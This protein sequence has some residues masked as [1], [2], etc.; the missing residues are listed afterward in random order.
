MSRFRLRM[1]LC[2]E[3]H[4]HLGLITPRWGTVQLPGNMDNSCACLWV[5]ASESRVWVIP[6][7]AGMMKCWQVWIHA[8]MCTMWEHVCLSVCGGASVMDQAIP[9]MTFLWAS[10]PVYV[11]ENEL[12]V[13]VCAW[14]INL[15]PQRQD[16]RAELKTLKMGECSGA[17]TRFQMCFGLLKIG[18]LRFKHFRG[19]FLLSGRLDCQR[20][21][22]L[23]VILES[24]QLIV[25]IWILSSVVSN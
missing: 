5:C 21:L 1:K 25:T 14:W 19:L 13:C 11:C 9:G 7:A 22:R 10:V 3:P 6:T 2:D 23:Y 17:V 8:C 24:M 12:Y 4:N 16:D 18:E 15:S 20:L